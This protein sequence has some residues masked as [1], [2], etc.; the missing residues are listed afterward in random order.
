MVWVDERVLLFLS[1][2][3]GC[4]LLVV[5]VCSEMVNSQTLSLELKCG[6]E[7]QKVDEGRGKGGRPKKETG[8]RAT[9][10]PEYPH[11]SVAVSDLI[12]IPPFWSF[13]RHL[14]RNHPHPL[15]CN[16][17]VTLDRGRGFLPWDGG[18]DLFN[19]GLL[20][21]KPASK[22]HYATLQQN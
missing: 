21:F 11:H 18:D 1:G 19:L 15:W 6:Q 14:L 13:K 8:A 17:R 2:E 20:F 9:L 22:S 5:V 7:E 12:C 10:H 16:L 3:V 4:W